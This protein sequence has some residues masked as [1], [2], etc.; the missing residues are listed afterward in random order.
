MNQQEE[1][2]ARPF[3]VPA[4]QDRYLSLLE[5]PKGMLKLAHGLGHCDDLDMRHAKLV[6]VGRQ[7]VDA[8][9]K[10]LKQK[11]SPDVCHVMSSHPRIDEQD[12][13]LRKALEEAAG[14]TTGTLI[15]CVPGKLAYFEFE[16]AGE[17]YILQR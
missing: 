11:G 14:Q 9:E 5:S 16:D 6:P 17:L 2:S 13:P 8:L 12:M 7:N 1:Q 10:V 15:S 3:I 4:K